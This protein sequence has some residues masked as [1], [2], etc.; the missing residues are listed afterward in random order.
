MKDSSLSG[1]EAVQVQV[2]SELEVTSQPFVGRWNRLVS[3]TNWE[4]GRIITQWRETLIDQDVSATEYS[5]EAW[6]ILV[7][8]VTGQ[9]V[10]RLRRVYQRF[11]PSYEQYDGLYWSHFQAALDWGDAEMWLEGAVQNDW[12]VSQMRRQRWET[13]GAVESDK[14][15]EDDVIKNEL[16]EDFEPALDQ[17]PQGEA[18]EGS[19]SE[20]Q[21]LAAGGPRSEGPDFGD[22]DAADDRSNSAGSAPR[23]NGATIYAEDDE[24]ETIDFVRPF[25]NLAEL[26]ADLTAAFDAYKLAVLFHKSEGWQQVSRDDV[27]ASLDALKALALAPSADSSPL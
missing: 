1:G 27:L 10:G 7:G 6:A 23:E 3:T 11:G 16:D 9:H 19:Y 4:K 25:A 2:D 22:E 17:S 21:Q 8:G 18:V 24:R 5:D 14:P 20:V 15:Q 12:S 13:L 26:P